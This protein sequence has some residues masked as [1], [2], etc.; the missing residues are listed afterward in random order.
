MD[1]IAVPMVALAAIGA[2]L[3]HH[4]AKRRLMRE[5][6][7]WMTIHA[8]AMTAVADAAVEVL[9]VDA[10]MAIETAQARLM[11]EAQKRD[12]MIRGLPATGT[13]AAMAEARAYVEKKRA[14]RGLSDEK[15]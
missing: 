9:C 3:S 11:E 4:L 7:Q 10:G 6:R 8:R 15:K 13:P 2:F 5:K 1:N 14:E 12:P